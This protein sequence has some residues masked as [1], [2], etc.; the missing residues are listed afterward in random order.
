MGAGSDVTARKISEIIKFAHFI[1]RKRK[2]NNQKKI[3]VGRILQIL[4]SQ[5]GKS[6]GHKFKFDNAE[7]Y[8]LYLHNRIR[9]SIFMEPPRVNEVKI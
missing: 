4:F 3:N 2:G 1:M 6:S 8:K 7:T 5:W 9:S